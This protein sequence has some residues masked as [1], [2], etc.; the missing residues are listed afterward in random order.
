MLRQQVCNYTA[1]TKSVGS[2]AE[3]FPCYCINTAYADLVDL[4]HIH[5]LTCNMELLNHN[6][7]AGDFLKLG[8]KYGDKYCPD[9]RPDKTILA[10]ALAYLRDRA[11]KVDGIPKEAYLQ[12]IHEISHYYD[13]I[14]TANDDVDM[15]AVNNT[16]S[17]T[18]DTADKKHKQLLTAAL[19]KLG[20]QFIITTTDKAAGC[21]AVICKRWYMNKVQEKLCTSTYS[22]C[23]DTL[24]TICTNITEQLQKWNIKIDILQN[25]ETNKYTELPNMLPT[26]F[27]T[28]EAHKTPQSV[29]GVASVR[30]TIIAALARLLS[31]AQ[32]LCISTIDE[33]WCKIAE[34]CKITCDG[35]WVTS[36]IAKV[37]G[38]VQ[39]AYKY[40]ENWLNEMEVY[41]FT[42]MYDEFVHSDMELKLRQLAT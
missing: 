2:N 11:I 25:K 34:I 36:D 32:Q 4:D 39:Q 10:H 22:V 9:N 20:R 35:S 30:S 29:R 37:Q 12:W 28:L 8:T 17:K 19:Q 16:V 6:R 26:Y 15:N 42:S 5:I 31:S 33:L 3:E 13:T 18:T 23:D 40:A 41:D 7:L 1:I 14:V 24:N 21:Y 38:R 27:L